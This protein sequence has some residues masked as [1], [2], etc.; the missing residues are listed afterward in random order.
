MADRLENLVSHDIVYEVKP[1]LL[2]SHI[3]EATKMEHDELTDHLQ[4]YSPK[5]ISNMSW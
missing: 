3:N 2:K 1:V 4:V 5:M